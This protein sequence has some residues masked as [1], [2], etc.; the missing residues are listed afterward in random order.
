MVEDAVETR[1]WLADLPAKARTERIWLLYS[2]VW[3]A[4]MGGAMLTGAYRS[5][6]DPVYMVFG[7]ALG[8]PPL[9]LPWLLPGDPEGDRPIWERHW[10]R[11]NL[12]IG[13][14]VFVGSYY[15]THYFFD[16]MGMRYGFPVAWHVEAAVVGRRGGDVPLFL[17]PVTH[18][19][20]A[21]YFAVM[22]A[23][24]RAF[25]R[26]VTRAR[27]ANALFVMAVSYVIAWAETFFMASG[28][29]EDV[30]LYESRG[31]MLAFGSVFY[32]CLFM[33]SLPLYARLDEPFEVDATERGQP[34]LVALAVESL[35]AG[36]AAITLLEIWTWLIGPL[37]TL[38]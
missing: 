4:M 15:V 21:T 29:I 30:F 27:W 28:V 7:L 33:V 23:A 11:A 26:R 35:G 37:D 5:W 31:R 34:G 9:L 3:M 14:L 1:P 22:V 12:W 19:Y 10:F 18:A 25:R 36:L 17:Y 38:T 8:L 32:G 13:L 2:P 24:W 20:F 6:S 16:V